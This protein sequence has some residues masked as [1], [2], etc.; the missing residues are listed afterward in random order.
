LLLL[1]F[2]SF[3]SANDAKKQRIIDYFSIAQKES[4]LEHYS[5]VVIEPNAPIVVIVDNLYTEDKHGQYLLNIIAKD[6]NPN[7]FIFDYSDNTLHNSNLERKVRAV[8]FEDFLYHLAHRYA[9]QKIIV[10]LSIGTVFPTKELYNRYIKDIKEDMY[11]FIA[12]IAMLPNV[13]LNKACANI[14]TTA[15]QHALQQLTSDYS[16]Q[17]AVIEYLS[18]GASAPLA[19]VTNQEQWQRIVALYKQYLYKRK[20]IAVDLEIYENAF[21][22][23]PLELQKRVALVESITPETFVKQCQ[24]TT[25]KLPQDLRDMCQTLQKEKKLD[26]YDPK[27]REKLYRFAAVMQRYKYLYPDLFIGRYEY[28]LAR[29]RS[30][31][32]YRGIN[33]FYLH[34]DRQKGNYA[35]ALKTF[36]DINPQ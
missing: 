13:Y 30:A 16:R 35:T 14:D 10:N 27:G 31:E 18:K 36:M 20:Y 34:G 29:S 9:D 25:K 4:F 8:N 19:W 7:I 28:D 23:F 12:L 32:F 5:A 15:L 3:L 33:A 6:D 24:K 22:M 21:K 17:R 11:N 26:L 2:T 1:F